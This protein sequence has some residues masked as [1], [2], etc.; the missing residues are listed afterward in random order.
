MGIKKERTTAETK[1]LLETLKKRVF[2]C[3]FPSTSKR[4]LLLY[5]SFHRRINKRH[6]QETQGIEPPLS[7]RKTQEHYK[8]ETKHCLYP[9]PCREKFLVL[10]CPH[11]TFSG[12]HGKMR[13]PCSLTL[14]TDSRVA[15]YMVEPGLLSSEQQLVPPILFSKLCSLNQTSKCR[16][17]FTKL[18]RCRKLQ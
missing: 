7:R 16:I 15:H 17:C 13:A 14:F 8:N 11:S 5:V 2:S 18:T 9:I 12:Q 1:T 3:C 10:Q 6:V 4:E